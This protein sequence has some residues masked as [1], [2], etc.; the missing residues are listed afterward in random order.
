MTYNTK[1]VEKIL[2][3]HGLP[4]EVKVVTEKNNPSL[5]LAKN[6]GCNL[7][8]IAKVI[9]FKTKFTNIPIV[10]ILSGTNQIDEKQMRNRFGE[11]LITAEDELVESLTGFSSDQLPPFGH[12]TTIDQVYIDADILRWDT[13]WTAFGSLNN[14]FHI[15][16]KQLIK[17]V[18]GKVISVT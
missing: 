14:F 11:K 1:S 9:V 12:K 2:S 17:L 7:G 3:Q 13:L 8:Q 5:A 4:C 16:T 18:G 6:L 15:Q 10:F